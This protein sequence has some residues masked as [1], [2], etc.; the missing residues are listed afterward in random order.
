[1]ETGV[2]RRCGIKKLGS[3]GQATIRGSL[4][5]VAASPWVLASSF[6]AGPL[7]PRLSVTPTQVSSESF[8][9]HPQCLVREREGQPG[10]AG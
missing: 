2:R 10:G 1:M 3:E 5:C 6:L 7:S 8:L 9:R 4:F